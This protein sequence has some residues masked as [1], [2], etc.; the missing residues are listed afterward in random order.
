MFPL[1]LRHTMIII[2]KEKHVIEKLRAGE[3]LPT[4]RLG[5]SFLAG[6]A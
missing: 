6:T 5:D 4:A 3:P 1:L 2:I